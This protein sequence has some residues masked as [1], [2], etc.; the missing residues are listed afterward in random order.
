MNVGSSSDYSSKGSRQNPLLGP[1]SAKERLFPS[2]ARL[3]STEG[4]GCV[5]YWTALALVTGTRPEHQVV[6]TF[7]GK[8][9]PCCR[10]ESNSFLAFGNSG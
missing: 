4:I 9:T 7:T 3:S 5:C 6:G 10:I 2:L 8:M 1:S